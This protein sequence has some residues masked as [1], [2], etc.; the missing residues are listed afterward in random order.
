MNNDR[1]DNSAGCSAGSC[2]FIGTIKRV[3]EIVVSLL[4]SGLML[5]NADRGAKNARQV[6]FISLG[7]FSI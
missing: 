4:D 3:V 2:Y 5:E 7:F 1:S 6:K